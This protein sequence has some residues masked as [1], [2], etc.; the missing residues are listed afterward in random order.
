MG[1]PATIRPLE[2]GDEARAYTLLK[3]MYPSLDRADFEPRLRRMA[4]ND[5]YELHGLYE[6]E[7]LIGVVGFI[8]LT[9]LIYDDYVWVHDLVIVH[10]H[11][12]RGLGTRLMDHVHELAVA[13]GRTYVALAAHVSDREAQRFYEDHLDYERRGV[14]FR[15]AVRA[16]E[17]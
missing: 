10:E 11:R 6:G 3:S 14:F 2:E 13:E 15:R 1:Q 16:G 12:G 8:R 7:A 9:N 17:A 5:G 4:A